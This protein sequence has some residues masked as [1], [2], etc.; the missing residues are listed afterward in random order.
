MLLS[1]LLSFHLGR[2][3]V[4]AASQK[5][6]N[7]AK[8][9]KTARHKIRNMEQQP[10]KTTTDTNHTQQT[11]HT[12]QILIQQRA[13]N[14]TSTRRHQLVTRIK[15]WNASKQDKHAIKSNKYAKTNTHTN[16]INNITKSSN[17]LHEPT[18][19]RNSRSINAGWRMIVDDSQPTPVNGQPMAVIKDLYRNSAGLPFA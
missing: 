5:N 9:I 7:R 16:Y 11:S 14:P 3:D 10:I 17:T 18:A 8:R 4:L 19:S 2:P 13:N 12:K 1:V 6:S 15:Q